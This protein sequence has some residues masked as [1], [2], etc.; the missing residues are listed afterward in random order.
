MKKLC[1]LLLI[2]AIGTTA[3][4]QTARIAHRSHSGSNKNFSITGYGNFGLG[5]EEKKARENKK[6]KDIT[7]TATDTI[8]KTVADTVGKTILLPKKQLRPKKKV[9]KLNP[10]HV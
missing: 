10:S 1:F 8:M 6:K 7:I 9:K 2:G 4:A 5:E 3:N